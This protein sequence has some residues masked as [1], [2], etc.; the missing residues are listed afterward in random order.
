MITNKYAV[1]T[2]ESNDQ[3][4]VLNSVRFFPKNREGLTEAYEFAFTQ[5]NWQ[6]FFVEELVDCS[7]H[8]Y[9]GQVD[10]PSPCH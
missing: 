1:L 8:F 3:G 10:E 2:T 7:E 4:E 5:P 6:I 9:H